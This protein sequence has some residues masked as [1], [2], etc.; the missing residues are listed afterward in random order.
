MLE[1]K[2]SFLT[3]ILTDHEEL[4]EM[5]VKENEVLKV[6]FRFKQSMWENV[7]ATDSNRPLP[8]YSEEICLYHNSVLK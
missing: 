8:L 1:L 3:K 4:L 2:G 5:V 6:A 7:N